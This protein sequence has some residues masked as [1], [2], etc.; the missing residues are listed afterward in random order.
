MSDGPLVGAVGSHAVGVA[1]VI[2]PHPGMGLP[3]PALHDGLAADRPATVASPA[4]A[5]GQTV[6]GHSF[7]EAADGEGCFAGLHELP[8]FFE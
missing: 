8:A 3:R 6:A 4:A 1:Y 7:A 2:R 5:N